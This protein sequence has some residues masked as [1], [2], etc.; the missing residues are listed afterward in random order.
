MKM[1]SLNYLKK[2]IWYQIK[3]TLFSYTFK[4][5]ISQKVKVYIWMNFLGYKSAVHWVFSIKD[6]E[7]LSRLL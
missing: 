1:I 6:N 3:I 7:M 5:V 4:C 2:K